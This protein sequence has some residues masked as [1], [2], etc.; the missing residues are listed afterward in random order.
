MSS[1]NGPGK[2]PN[3]L[4]DLTA[5]SDS[6]LEVLS[7][8]PAAGSQ[9]SSRDAATKPS[10]ALVPKS[11]GLGDSLPKRGSAE[12]AV[13]TGAKPSP[14]KR[15][16]QPSGGAQGFA[17]Q[18][19]PGREKRSKLTFHMGA[20]ASDGAAAAIAPITSASTTST[21]STPSSQAADEAI[22][23]E[24]DD[25]LEIVSVVEPPKPEPQQSVFAL[26]RGDSFML[27]TLGAS[28]PF[29]TTTDLVRH[30]FRTAMGSRPPTHPAAPAPTASPAPRPTP[31]STMKHAP[32]KKTQSKR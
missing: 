12:M 20:T 25:E 29:Q 18:C 14:V 2:M 9:S 5:A 30:V 24:S 27:N 28:R 19:P 7:S 21:D 17:E 26:S 22:L 10:S 23:I 3:Q 1:F 15:K 4:L 8:P 11:M 6:E 13:R 16:N 32:L 31:V